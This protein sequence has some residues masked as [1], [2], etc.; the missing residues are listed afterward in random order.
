[1]AA[2]DTAF[3]GGQLGETPSYEI[4][5]AMYYAATAIVLGAAVQLT[6]MT[7]NGQNIV[8]A[9]AASGP[10]ANVVGIAASAANIGQ[11]VE[12]VHKGVCQGLA[13]ATALTAGENLSPVAA[14]YTLGAASVTL[15]DNCA[16][17]LQAIAANTLGYVFVSNS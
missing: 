13:G 17:A 15:G 5:T 14:G 2:N 6:V 4:L 1:M 9:S 11:Y 16:V 12:V 7:L 8:A 3:P 10:G